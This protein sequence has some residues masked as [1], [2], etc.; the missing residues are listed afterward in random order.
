L[1]EFD[2]IRILMGKP[3]KRSREGKRR[4][5]KVREKN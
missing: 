2:G 1:V 3:K 4:K 5:K